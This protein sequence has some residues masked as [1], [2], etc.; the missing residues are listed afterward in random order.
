[1]NAG[2]GWDDFWIHHVDGRYFVDGDRFDYYVDLMRQ[3]PDQARSLLGDPRDYWFHAYEPRPGDVV[4][5]VG[6]GIGTDSMVFSEAVGPGGRVHAIEAHP[7]TYRKLLKTVEF[8]RLSNVAPVHAAIM[9]EACD[10]WIEDLENHVANAVSVG[11]GHA[12]LRERVQAISL[13]EFCD[14]QGIG[15][16]DLVKMNIEGAERYAVRGMTEVL[17][18]AKAVAIACHDFLPGR[19]DEFRT[20]GLIL[21]VLSR[22][23]FRVLT[24]DDDPRE[25]V[26]DHV[27]GVRD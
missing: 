25:F 8:N 10:V 11:H 16:V 5:D 27:H 23:G 24:R 20:K 15:R 4:L 14:R 1:L 9:H 21:D 18:R 7:K 6:A 2:V 3:W 12:H 19:G 26:R 17:K 13:D 22:N